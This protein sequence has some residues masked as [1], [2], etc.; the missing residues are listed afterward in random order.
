MNDQIGKKT[1]QKI[2]RRKKKLIIKD[3]IEKNKC[4]SPKKKKK[5]ILGCF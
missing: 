3:Q 2:K 1:I 5:Q 4:K